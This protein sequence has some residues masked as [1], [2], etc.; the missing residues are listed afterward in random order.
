MNCSGNRSA[1][2]HGFSLPTMLAWLLLIVAGAGG[3]WGWQ[4]LLLLQQQQQQHIEQLTVLQGEQQHATT[5]GSNVDKQLQQITR[6]LAEQQQQLDALTG[7]D[8]RDWLLDDAESLAALAGQRLALSADVDA[9]I[10]LLE[11]ADRSLAQI[12]DPATL[13]TRAALATDIEALQ[14]AAQTDITALVLRLGALGQQVNSLASTPLPVTPRVQDTD[15]I[16]AQLWQGLPIRV[17]EYAGQPILLDARQAAS[18]R[19]ALHSLL[20]QAQLALLQRRGA[21][22]QQAL[23]QLQALIRQLYRTDDPRVSALLS[24]LQRLQAEPTE[25]TLPDIGTGL[26]AIRQLATE[27]KP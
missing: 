7:H 18:A 11:A 15:N 9:A 21:V 22:Y 4:Q 24:A 20:H 14:G 2:Q 12:N 6:S 3:W 13:P 16:W 10:A 5:L 26:D 1:S 25:A 19:L 27:V 23:E 8:Q 17:S